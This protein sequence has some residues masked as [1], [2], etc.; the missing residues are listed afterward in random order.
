MITQKQNTE[1]QSTS[2]YKRN[3]YWDRVK[4]SISKTP[5]LKLEMYTAS[6]VI[7]TNFKEKFFN[8]SIVDLQCCVSFRY[9]AKWSSYICFF[10]KFFS[11]IGYYKILNTVQFPVLDSRPLLFM[12]FIYSGMY[13]LTP[14][15]YEFS[16]Q[17]AKPNCS[18][19]LLLPGLLFES[20][21]YMN[22]Y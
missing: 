20:R 6:E 4:R 19:L 17:S 15:P 5:F 10:F 18:A 13:M 21:A 8:S 2:N 14:N 3:M 16:I 11:I 9:T 22:T 12:Y 1:R 7:N